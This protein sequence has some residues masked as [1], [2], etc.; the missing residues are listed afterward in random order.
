MAVRSVHPDRV[1][2]V[3]EREATDRTARLNIARK[4][5]TDPGKRVR[6]DELRRP[7]KAFTIPVVDPVGA[8]PRRRTEPADRW[9]SFIAQVPVAVALVVI[10]LTLLIGVG[11]NLVTIVAFDL[12]AVTVAYY[13]LYAF[14]GAALRRSRR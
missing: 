14:V 10:S 8:W 2:S 1:D 11:S 7:G 9:R 3:H 5:L 4:W 12:S 6:Y 13:G